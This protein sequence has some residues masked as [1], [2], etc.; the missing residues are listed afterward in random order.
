MRWSSWV[1]GGTGIPP[2]QPG[3][4]AGLSTSKTVTKAILAILLAGATVLSAAPAAEEKH[5]SVYSP[6]ATYTLPVLER[7]G[8]EYVGLL[9][10]LEPLGRVSSESN[11][12]SLKLRYNALDAEFAAGSTHAKIMDAITGPDYYADCPVRN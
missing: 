12:R 11:G 5:I 6:V 10:L 3:G 1:S 9:E 4:D 8:H 7:S 2:V